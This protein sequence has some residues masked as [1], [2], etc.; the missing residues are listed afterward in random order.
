MK[1]EASIELSWKKYIN[2]KF[3][4]I[5]KTKIPFGNCNDKILV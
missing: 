3:L 5:Y 1:T 2:K 4:E